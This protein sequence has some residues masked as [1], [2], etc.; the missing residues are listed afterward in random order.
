MSIWPRKPPSAPPA[1]LPMPSPVTDGEDS[2]SAEATDAPAKGSKRRSSTRRASQE[3]LEVCIDEVLVLRTPP[4]VTR[5]L[6]YLMADGGLPNSFGVTSSIHGEG[7]TSISRTLA[8]LIASDWRQSTCWVDLN[9]WKLKSPAHEATLFDH[10]MSDVVQG[11]AMPRDV[12]RETSIPALS[13]VSA[14]EVPSSSRARFSTSQSLFDAIGQLAKQFEYLVLDLPPV[15][16]TSDAVTLSGLTNGFLLVVR[17]EAASSVQVEGGTGCPDLG[18][19]PRCGAEWSANERSSI[20]A[21]LERG[22]GARYV[23]VVT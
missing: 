18:S 9:W 17:Q 2:V 13:F 14:G 3:Q 1:S 4:T 6:R 7:V 16:T 10:T 11:R 23:G 20:A 19:L 8:A 21:H 15:L 12:P 5:S 22:L